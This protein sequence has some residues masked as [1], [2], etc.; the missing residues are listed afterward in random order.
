MAPAWRYGSAMP[1]VTLQRLEPGDAGTD[2][3]VREMIRMVE[4]G[5]ADLGIND[6]A[7]SIIRAANVRQKDYA[8]EI[9]ALFRWVRDRV[10]YVKDPIAVELVR[11]ARET[12][13]RRAGDCDDKAVLLA[14]LLQSIGHNTRFKVVA[15]RP[16]DF[17]HVLIE[18]SHKAQWVPLDPTVER[19]APGW[20]SPRIIR[21]KVYG[22]TA[23]V[24]DLS[25]YDFRQVEEVARTINRTHIEAA[26]RAEVAK[27]LAAG[28]LSLVDVRLS[29]AYLA[30]EAHFHLPEWQRSMADKLASEAERVLENR[31]VLDASRTGMAGIGDTDNLGGFFSSV[32]NGIKSVASVVTTIA[33]APVKAVASLVTLHPGQAWKDI[34]V[35]VGTAAAVAQVVGPFLVLIPGVGPVV[36]GAITSVGTI[37]APRPAGQS[38][39]A[40]AVPVSEIPTGTQLQVTAAS[41][42]ATVQ[43][44]VTPGAAAATV[45]TQF[46]PAVTAVDSGSSLFTSKVAGIPMWGLLAAG[47][48]VLILVLK[49]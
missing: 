27:N 44:V 32:W 49:K 9:T 5:R 33:T 24:A 23:T 12:L 3:T 42:P 17:H 34:K 10:R 43:P 21:R 20:E 30:R 16:G 35:G 28:K 2:Q 40:D 41:I 8:G 4:S 14:T 31:P 38:Y 36:A 11:N 37:L 18:V 7:L 1:T 25:G 47:A 29:R 48:V 22:N 26:A 15:T 45:V 39:P 13:K 6:A 46:T 19:A